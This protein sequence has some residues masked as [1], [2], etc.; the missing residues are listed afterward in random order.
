MGNNNNNNNSVC[1]GR[2]KSG[3]IADSPKAWGRGRVGGAIVTPLP[4]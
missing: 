1:A 4:T 3:Q 2:V